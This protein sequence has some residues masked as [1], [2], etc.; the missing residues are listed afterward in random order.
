MRREKHPVA[1]TLFESS[2]GMKIH[3]FGKCSN[4]P[5]QCAVHTPMGYLHGHGRT[6][7][8]AVHDAMKGIRALDKARLIGEL[9]QFALYVKRENENRED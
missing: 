3:Y 4:S 1:Y 6:P 7:V 2:N 5:Y 8:G 9:E